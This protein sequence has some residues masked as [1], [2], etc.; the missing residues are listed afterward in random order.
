MDRGKGF[1]G[2]QYDDGVPAG[3]RNPLRRRQLF[4]ATRVHDNTKT[5]EAL[6]IAVVHPVDAGCRNR[7]HDAAPVGGG[8][9]Q[10]VLWCDQQV[11]AGLAVMTSRNFV[12]KI[13]LAQVD[14]TGQGADHLALR[15]ANRQRQTENRRI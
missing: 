11:A 7:L 10:F 15:I 1:C 2:G 3:H 8:D 13:G 6:H 12:Q 9:N 4:D 14:H 5:V